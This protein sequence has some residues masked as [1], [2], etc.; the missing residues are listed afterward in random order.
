MTNDKNIKKLEEEILHHRD[1]YYSNQQEIPDATYDNL[2]DDL[3]LID[4]ENEV[5]KKVGV[6]RK[7]SPWKKAGHIMPMF[8][9]DK[10]KDIHT[11]KDLYKKIQ[12]DF[13]I[14]EHKLDGISLEVI[15]KKGQLI[16]AITRGEGIEGEDITRNVLKMKNVKTEVS[17]K[18]AFSVR[19]EMLLFEDDFE[20]VNKLRVLNGDDP[21]VNQRNGA[22]GLANKLDGTHSE[23]NTLLYYDIYFHDNETG[24]DTELE[25]IQF[26]EKLFGS[27]AIVPYKLVNIKDVDKAYKDE[28]LIRMSLPYLIDGLVHKMNDLVK[29]E[30]IERENNNDNPKTQIAWK[31]PASQIGCIMEGVNWSTSG[32][33]I[34]PVG[35]L[36]PTHIVLPDGSMKVITDMQEVAKHVGVRIANVTLNNLDWMKEKGVGLNDFV[37]IERSNDVI[38][39]LVKVIESSGEPIEIPKECPCCGGKTVI[40]GCNLTCSEPLCPAKTLD[41]LYKWIEIFKI[42]DFGPSRIAKLHEMKVLTEPADFYKLQ[43]EKISC[44]D[45]LGE[46][47]AENIISQFKKKEVSLQNLL[48]GLAIDL[49]GESTVEKIIGAGYD[50]IDKVFAITESEIASIDGLGEKIGESFVNGLQ[51]RKQI[52]INLL[53]VVSIVEPERRDT[54]NKLEGKTFCVTGTLSMKRDV[55]EQM[56]KDNGGKIAGVTKKLNYLIVGTDAGSKQTKAEDLGVPCIGEKEFLLMLS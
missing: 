20:T 5:L 21:F 10:L 46:K 13:Y 25:K 34:T 37:L 54:T 8:S 49:I 33:R 23:Y 22:G 28:L 52:I 56:V 50:T 27:K 51:E 32:S 4:P 35:A 30:A 15:Y 19:A 48:S 12:T 44:I 41:I 17:C 7:P 14:Q 40:V 3:R 36:K 55:I 29:A 31:F 2:E 1:A 16:Q 18:D 43:S 9:L 39:T 45:G 26:L 38:P 53:N 47:T 24:F 42:K 6:S 11:S